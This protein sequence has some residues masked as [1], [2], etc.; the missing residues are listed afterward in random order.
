MQQ[1]KNLKVV[2]LAG[3]LA[4]PSVG[5]FFA[6]LGAEVIKVE[7]P[8]TGG[9][10]T[11]SWKLPSETNDEKYSAYF[12]SINGGNKQFKFIDIKSD[13]EELVTLLKDADVFI[14]NFT[15]GKADKLGLGYDYLK[16]INPKLIVANITGY[17]EASDKPAFDVVLQAESG[18]LSMT[19][20]PD[21]PPVKLP[22][23]FID[24]LTAHQL[25]EAILIA[26]LK[27]S[28]TGE[29]SYISVSLYETAVSSL[30]NQATNYLV[31][32]HVAKPIGSL[33][34]NIAPYGE[35]Y[36]TKDGKS[37]VLAVGS[38]RQFAA[39][40]KCLSL[41][42]EEDERFKDNVNRVANRKVLGD[43]LSGAITKMESISLF[44]KFDELN[45]PYGVIHSIDE[46]FQQ[47]LA[48]GL[49]KTDN[50][51]ITYVTSTPFKIK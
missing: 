15:K 17:G 13:K 33:H 30:T 20:H 26:L 18:Y 37:F 25:K 22:V 12:S 49:V 42:V 35:C 44:Q 41:S 34:P 10:V 24:V 6:E 8:K 46:V 38:N 40:C 31:A 36:T 5:M 29:G 23:A 39:L 48:K 4:G 27:R 1:F 9:D 51:G 2:E 19:G 11:R 45:V 7:N 47:P 43:L 50:N 28:E 21:S 14:T 16:N 3:V 32:G